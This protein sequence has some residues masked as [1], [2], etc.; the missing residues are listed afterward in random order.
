MIFKRHKPIRPTEYALEAARSA[1][2]SAADAGRPVRV[3]FVCL[4]NE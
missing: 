1:V 3:L 4:G 2:K